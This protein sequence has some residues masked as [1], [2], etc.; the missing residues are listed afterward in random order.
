VASLLK[1]FSPIQ[2]GLD[3]KGIPTSEAR[4]QG[5][6]FLQKLK[7]DLGL[8]AQFSSAHISWQLFWSGYMTTE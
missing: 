6:C 1:S 8:I 3:V 4:I 5:S 2:S 7:S